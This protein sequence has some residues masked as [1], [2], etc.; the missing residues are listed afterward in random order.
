MSKANTQFVSIV[1]PVYY[2]AILMNNIKHQLIIKS[3]HTLNF[4]MFKSE[5]SI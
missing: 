4:A 1:V 2:A 5:V 3:S